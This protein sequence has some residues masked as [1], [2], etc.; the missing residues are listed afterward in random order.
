MKVMLNDATSYDISHDIIDRPAGIAMNLSDLHVDMHA[1]HSVLET[2]IFAKIE[3]GTVYGP[4]EFEAN[5]TTEDLV[6]GERFN[7]HAIYIKDMKVSRAEID[8]ASLEHMIEA[9]EETCLQLTFIL[10]N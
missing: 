4:V 9:L 7:Q 2:S 5:E 10:D 1:N 8:E 6:L 3:V